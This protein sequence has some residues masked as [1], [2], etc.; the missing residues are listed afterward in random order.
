MCFLRHARKGVASVFVLA[1][2]LLCSP[3]FSQERGEGPLITTAPQGIT[4]EEI[5]Q[6]FAAREKQFAAAREKYTYKESVI[7]QTLE[8]DTVDGEYSQSWD[9]NFDNEG[10]RTMQVTYAPMSTLSR[11]QMTTEDL[12]DIQNLMPFVLTTDEIPE[13]NISYAGQ[14]REDEL[15]TYV[16]DVSP[17]RM[18]KDR[19][20]FEGRIWVDNRDFQ[21]V[22]TRGKSVPDIHHG[23]NENLFPRF[24]TYREQIDNVYWFPT[25]TRADDEL[26]FQSGDVHIRVIVRY[27]NYKR[28][29]SSSRIVFNG[30]TVDNNGPVGSDQASP[31]RSGPPPNPMPQSPTTPP[32]R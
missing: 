27:T 13:Y 6:R 26:H 32:G 25:Y 29:G 11:V 31:P 30:K 20:Y 19:R 15:Q 8:G 9:V 12:H 2:L 7:V 14:Q 10:H 5:I 24:T 23:K 18:E 21:I 1:A 16:F 3:A 28:F 4:P 22:M 17:R